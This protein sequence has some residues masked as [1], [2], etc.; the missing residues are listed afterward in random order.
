MTEGAVPR[1]DF[2]RVRGKTW[3]FAL[4]GLVLTSG[5]L[6]SAGVQLSM[7]FKRYREQAGGDLIIADDTL[8]TVTGP[9]TATIVVHAAA[10]QLVPITTIYHQVDVELGAL[11]PAEIYPLVQGT[12]RV[13]PWGSE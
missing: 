12:I 13:L 8:I 10:T 7:R 11:S 9:D 1:Y 6:E 5:D 4:S 2:I 3:R